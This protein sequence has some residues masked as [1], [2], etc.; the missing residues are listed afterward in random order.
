[1]TSSTDPRDGSCS[2]N[3]LVNIFPLTNLSPTNVTSLHVWGPPLWSL[4]LRTSASRELWVLRKTSSGW[5]I[6]DYMFNRSERAGS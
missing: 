5:R 2:F 3:L 6:V 4:C 1:M